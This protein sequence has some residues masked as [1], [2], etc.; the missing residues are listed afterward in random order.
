[1]SYVKFEWQGI[2]RW[3]IHCFDWVFGFC[4]LCLYQL[5][6]T[7]LDEEVGEN[8]FTYSLELGAMPP[9]ALATHH[10]SSCNL[11]MGGF[12]CYVITFLSSLYV[13]CSKFWIISLSGHILGLVL[14]FWVLVLLFISTS[15]SFYFFYDV[16]FV[17]MLL[18]YSQ[19]K[20]LI[21]FFLPLAVDHID[22]GNFAKLFVGSVPRTATEEEV[23]WLSHS[24]QA[25]NLAHIYAVTKS[26]RVYELLFIFNFVM[27]FVY[28]F[29]IIESWYLAYLGIYVLNL[30]CC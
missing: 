23:S 21:V 10:L 13:G 29:V 25:V 30:L 1:M 17:D 20:I 6:G 4:V 9:L 27:I 24:Y 8:E 26:L 22:G 7:S 14:C 18:A 12:I 2:P 11:Y 3:S 5:V 15:F 28:S 16:N 19:P